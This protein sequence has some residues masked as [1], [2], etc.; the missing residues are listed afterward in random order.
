MI[1][2]TDLILIAVINRKKDL[3][4]ARTLGWY[5]IPLRFAPKIV[6]V[7]AVAFYQTAEF[8]SEKWSIHYAAR[9]NGVELMRRIDLFRDEENHPRAQEEYYKLQLGPVM[10]LPQPI[11]AGRWRRITFLYTTGERLLHARSMDDLVIHDRQR[12]IIW[13]ALRDRSV[14]LTGGERMDFSDWEPAIELLNRWLETDYP[15]Y[16]GN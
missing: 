11:P 12:D 10:E 16:P 15:E 7:D 2:E 4:V 6:R 9:L 14:G 5:R 1:A 3:E 13:K 8:L